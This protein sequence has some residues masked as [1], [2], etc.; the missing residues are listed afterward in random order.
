MLDQHRDEPLEAAKN[1]T[2]DHH[3]LVFLVVGA[4]VLQPKT[5]RHL[6]VELDGGAL[7]LPA[8]GVGDVEVDLRPVKRAVA[9][10]H[11][12]GRAGGLQGARQLRLSVVPRRLLTQKLRGACGQLHFVRQAEVAVHALHQ[13][14]QP[15]DFLADLRLH[16]KT[17][18]IVLRELAHAREAG[19]HT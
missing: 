14:Q 7:P 6:V 11:P 12:I 4:H 8:D 18:R 3:R 9:F 16:H 17:M 19:E 13:T 1:R 10:V 2:V 5:L 15:L